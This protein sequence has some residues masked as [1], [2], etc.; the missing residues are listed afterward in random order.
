MKWIY[1]ECKEEIDILTR[2]HRD[3]NLCEYNVIKR[4]YINYE[5]AESK[6]IT[7]DGISS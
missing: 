2:H 6:G 3:V 1:S 5:R 4:G 7:Q